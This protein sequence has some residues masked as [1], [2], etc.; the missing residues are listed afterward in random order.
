MHR[1]NLKIEMVVY[2]FKINRQYFVYW[3]DLGE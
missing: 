3:A 1:Q 2:K